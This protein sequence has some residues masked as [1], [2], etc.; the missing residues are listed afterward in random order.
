MSLTGS[1]LGCPAPPQSWQIISDSTT[2]D[3]YRSPETPSFYGPAGT[4]VSRGFN[5][6]NMEGLKY[7]RDT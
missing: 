7:H 3:D 5:A 6:A 4:E 1:K 2:R